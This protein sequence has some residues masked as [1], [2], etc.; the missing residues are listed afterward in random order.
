MLFTL[1]FNF[2]FIV[3][4]EEGKETL[5]KRGHDLQQ[6]SPSGHESQLQLQLWLCGMGYKHFGYVGIPCVVHDAENISDTT[7]SIQ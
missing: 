4:S 3:V 2:Y 6:R 5:N 7:N 1:S